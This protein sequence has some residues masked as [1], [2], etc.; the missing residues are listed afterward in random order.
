[1]GSRSP[2]QAR[3][4]ENNQSKQDSQ[5]CQIPLILTS[6]FFKPMSVILGRIPGVISLSNNRSKGKG[7]SYELDEEYQAHQRGEQEKDEFGF[8]VTRLRS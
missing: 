7:R 1:M 4:Q 2:Q 6:R 3:R 8:H 5:P